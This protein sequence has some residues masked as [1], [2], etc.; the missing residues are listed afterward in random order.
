MV[1]PDKQKDWLGCLFSCDDN[2]FLSVWFEMML[3]NWLIG[4]TGEIVVEPEMLGSRPDFLIR[5]HEQEIVIEAKAF[6]ISQSE[7]NQNRWRS[8]VFSVIETIQLPYLLSVKTVKLSGFPDIEQLTQ[9]VEHWLVHSP[10]EDYV[11]RD[12]FGNIIIFESQ[13]IPASKN[14]H[15]YGQVR[16]HG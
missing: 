3:L 5:T 15:Y 4:G 11:F 13:Q 8:A 6:L 2:Q 9:G 12:R 10:N 1:S 16:E 7:R 14:R